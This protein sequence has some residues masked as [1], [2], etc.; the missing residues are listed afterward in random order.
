MKFNLQSRIICTALVTVLVWAHVLWDYFHDGIPV[1]YLFMDKNMPPFPNWLGAI[2]LPFFCW[3]LL[4]RIAKRVNNHDDKDSLKLV[5]MRF[6]SAFAVSL[7]ISVCFENGIEIPGLLLLSI[8]AQA[9][10]FPLYKSE[11]LLG[12]VLGTSYTFGAMIPMLF[13]VVLAGVFYLFFQIR[14]ITL[15]FFR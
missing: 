13:A 12:W 7:A 11:F 8:F 2:I 1:H 4:A 14:V 9:F 3:V 10:I 6:L 15:R 5:F